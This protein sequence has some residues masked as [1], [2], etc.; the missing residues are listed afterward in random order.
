LTLQPHLA[1]FPPGHLQFGK[2]APSKDRSTLS[3]W[4]AFN[5]A[6]VAVPAALTVASAAVF[7]SLTA[8]SVAAEAAFSVASV[9]VE[10]AFTAE[11]VAEA[12]ALTPGIPSCS[13][14]RPLHPS[15][16]LRMTLQQYFFLP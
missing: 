6:F 7:A 2:R 10:A 16:G 9:T 11:S 12:A 13:S 15:G 8:A 3:F 1:D 4:M 14:E 5:A